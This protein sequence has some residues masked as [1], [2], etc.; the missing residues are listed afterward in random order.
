MGVDFADFD[1]DGYPDLI[2][3]DLADQKYALYKNNKDGSFVYST[4]AS[5]IGRYTLRHSGWGIRFLDYDNDGLKDILVA[6]GHD[7]DTSFERKSPHLHYKEPM[8]LLRNTGKGFEDV[9]AKSGAVFEQR[10]VGRGLATGDLDND[11]RIDAVVSTNDGPAYLLHNE[12]VSNNHWLLLNLI[13]HKS[14]RDGIGA[15]IKI[16]TSKGG[17]YATASTTGSYLFSPAINAFTSESVPIRL[18]KRWRSAGQAA[19]FRHSQTLSQI[20]F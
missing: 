17:Q 9:S 20:K 12:T 2:V 19:S 11:G 1:N 16:T 15:V 18:F 4:P 5:G 6:Q 8:L 3:D 14:N 10:W 13:G 7:M